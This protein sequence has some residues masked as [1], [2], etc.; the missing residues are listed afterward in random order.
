ME[1]MTPA[2]QSVSSLNGSYSQ[3]GFE[4][5]LH[6]DSDL[7]P[8]KLII[9]TLK[10]TYDG[11]P[12]MPWIQQHGH[13]KKWKN[14]KVANGLAALA[15]ATA[16]LSSLPNPQDG[17]LGTARMIN[18][19]LCVLE[20]LAP[21]QCKHDPRFHTYDPEI[22]GQQDP[23]PYF[24]ERRTPGLELVVERTPGLPSTIAT[25]ATVSSIPQKP[26]GEDLVPQRKVRIFDEGVCVVDTLN[27]P[28]CEF[29]DYPLHK[30]LESAGKLASPAGQN[31]DQ[32]CN[33]KIRYDI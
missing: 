6:L 22:A 2:S 18:K 4:I 7:N 14:R 15:A 9:T 3:S 1:H 23:S 26:S 28:Q 33:I 10:D 32:Q 20:T 30:R 31:P 12:R 8:S 11:I 13:L 21:L 16:A 19:G 29:N 25:V 24:F 17:P 27:L 5:N